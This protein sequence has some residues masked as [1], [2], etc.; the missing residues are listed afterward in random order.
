[1]GV[2]KRM[3]TT[4]II[5]CTIALYSPKGSVSKQRNTYEARRRIN[6]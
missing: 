5:T 4:L 3:I 2:I 6:T 1:M